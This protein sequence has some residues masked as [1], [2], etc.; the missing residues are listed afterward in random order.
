MRL[1]APLLTLTALAL[2]GLA[3][4]Q[5]MLLLTAPQHQLTQLPPLQ[6]QTESQPP[7][8]RSSAAWQ[9]LFGEK[10]PPRAP[11]PPQQQ[12]EPQPPKPQLP[13]LE[14]LGYVLKGRVQ[15]GQATWAIVAHPSGEQ[16]VRQG[17]Q[18]REGI[19][20]LR[21]DAQGLW[22]SRQGAAAEVLG[23]AE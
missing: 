20:V 22:I 15:A 5:L 18:L 13:P 9:P 21:I 16:L 17:D 1:I 2:A 23:F 4:Q 14:S 7:Q 19:K 6:Q 10:Q 11:K 8:P 12:A 3:A